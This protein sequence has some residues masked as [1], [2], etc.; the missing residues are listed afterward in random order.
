MMT[1][2]P[3]ATFDCTIAGIESLIS[4]TFAACDG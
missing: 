4:F 2:F 3:A 1:C